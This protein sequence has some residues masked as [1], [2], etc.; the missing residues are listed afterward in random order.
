MTV[1][2]IPVTWFNMIDLDDQQNIW[3]TYNLNLGGG[4]IFLIDGDGK[5][6][7]IDPTSEKVTEILEEKGIA[8]N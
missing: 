7:A 2:M 3:L 4:G 6:L 5:I 8:K 1:L